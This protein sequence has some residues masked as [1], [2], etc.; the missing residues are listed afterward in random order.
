MP[1]GRTKKA[2]GKKG[3]GAKRVGKRKLNNPL[4]V[5]RP[6][7]FGVGRSLPPVQ[8]VTRFV[9]WPRYI[10]I[11]RQKRVLLTRLKVPPALHQFTQTLDK[12][13]ATETLKLL[14]KYRPETKGKKARRLRWEAKQ[15]AEG[16]DVPKKKPFSVKY[17]L[18]HITALVENNKAKLVVIAHDV[19]PIE[20]VVWLP[21]LCRKKGVPYCI[22]KGKARL[23]TV[24][25]QKTAT[26]VALTQVRQEDMSDLQ[27]LA[28]AFKSQYNNRGDEIRKQW[29]GQNTGIKSA[30]RRA[31]VQRVLRQ[32][33]KARTGK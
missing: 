13:Q 1:S 14:N 10:Q 7:T 31:A 9:K 28:S 19:D 27:R 22:I 11:Q 8:D 17:G 2:S 20:L 16:K 6:K 33:E 15:K 26:A 29:G 4:F 24:V 32:E 18:N 21:A 12:N 23:G 3:S 30:H 5:A 25:G